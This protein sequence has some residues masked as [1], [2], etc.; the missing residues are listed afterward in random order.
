MTA[1]VREQT[2]EIRG[3]QVRRIHV[4]VSG[5]TVAQVLCYDFV[6][7]AAAHGRPFDEELDRT[8]QMGMF[9]ADRISADGAMYQ[10]ASAT[11]YVLDGKC[12][13]TAKIAHCSEIQ[14]D[15][16]GWIIEN[17]DGTEIKPD[18][19]GCVPGSP[20]IAHR[21]LMQDDDTAEDE[22]ESDEG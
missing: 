13:R 19:S 2:G 7:A 17:P 12:I 11:S 1:S 10:V 21:T 5:H 4:I 8:I 6:E 20:P 15:S 3:V 18:E 9:A 22:D 16:A 14:P